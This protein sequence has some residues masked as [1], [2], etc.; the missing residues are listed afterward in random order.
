MNYN[1]KQVKSISKFMS[2]VLRHKPETI[3]ITLDNEG[4]TDVERLLRQMSL[5]GRPVDRKLLEHVVENNDKKRF[6]FSNDKTRIR[7]SQGHSVTL[8]L[9]YEATEPPVFL[10]HGTAMRFTES[11]F[12]SGLQKQD[13]HHVHLSQ[14]KSTAVNVGSRHGK[15]VV[16][17]VNALQ[18]HKDGYEFYVSENGVWLTDEVPVK[19]ICKE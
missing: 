16:L 3:N 10:Y 17:I 18:M 19:Y 14:E 1:Q 12:Q 8:N 7:A 11:I 4:W 15:P 5:S 9:G 6:A 13:R 2:L